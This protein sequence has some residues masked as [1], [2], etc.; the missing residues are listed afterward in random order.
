MIKSGLQFYIFDENGKNVKWD[1]H[2]LSELCVF[3]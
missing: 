1:M 3:L 2:Y